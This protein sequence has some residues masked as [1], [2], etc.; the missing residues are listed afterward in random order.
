MFSKKGIRMKSTQ[1]I[2]RLLVM[3]CLVA[4]LS[5]PGVGSA[6]SISGTTCTNEGQTRQV[7]NA[8]Y[9]CQKTKKG[10]LR[11]RPQ[12]ATTTGDPK[13]IVDNGYINLD[14]VRVSGLLGYAKNGMDK[15]EKCGRIG[16]QT[17]KLWFKYADGRIRDERW[18][19]NG[20]QVNVFRTD[21]YGNPAW[22]PVYVE[23]SGLDPYGEG[24]TEEN[25]YATTVWIWCANRKPIEPQKVPVSPTPGSTCSSGGVC[26]VGD[27]GPGGG[28]VFYVHPSGTFSSAG[29]DCGPSCRYLEAAPSDQSTGIEWATRTAACYRFASTSSDNDCLTHSVYSGNEWPAANPSTQRASEALGMGM[30]NT[31]QIHARL[32]TAGSAP[33]RNYAAGIAWAYTNN[34]KSDWHLPSERELNELCKYARNQTTGNIKDGCGASDYLVESFSLDNYWSS[35]EWSD[36]YALSQHFGLQA[37]LC[38]GKACKFRVRPVRAF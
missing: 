33:T 25:G 27:T 22:R 13:R 23:A 4:P 34:G 7:A 19:F 5:V 38:T 31:N 18:I 10:K 9:V 28:I 11:W 32:T 12:T 36:V 15:V 6:A 20:K 30:A 3:V 2:R 16:E 29:S 21:Q 14:G 26:A 37:R 35:S 17:V 24:W 1:V 8:K